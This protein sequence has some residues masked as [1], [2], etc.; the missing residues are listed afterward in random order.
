[1]RF[2]ALILALLAAG[3]VGAT[4]PPDP[5]KVRRC[6]AWCVESY[7]A[8]IPDTTDCIDACGRGYTNEPTSGCAKGCVISHTGDPAAIVR[9][10]DGCG[11]R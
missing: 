3:A 4:S 8:V 7:N 9:C 6:C 11:A 1:M 10:I 5:A 2:G